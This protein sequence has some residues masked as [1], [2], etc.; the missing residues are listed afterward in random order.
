[1]D[2]PRSFAPTTLAVFEQADLVFIVSTVD[3]PS[4]RN[5]QRGIPLLKRVLARGEDQL[6]LV[7]NRYDPSDSISQSDVERSLGL[8]VFYKVSNDYDAVMSSVNSG[9]PIVLNGGSKYTRDLNGLAAALT[10]ITAGSR[11][12][13]AGLGRLT[14]S[15][16]AAFGRGGKRQGGA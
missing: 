12:Q 13:R 5:I 7:L 4:L 15:M 9:K 6:R 8:K 10:G 16:R 1:V 14:A 3:L 11:G 2:T